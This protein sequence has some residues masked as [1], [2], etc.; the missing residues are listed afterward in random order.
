M[1]LTYGKKDRQSTVMM[2]C[3]RYHSKGKH[4]EENGAPNSI[5][6]IGTGIQKGSDAWVVS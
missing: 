3:D 5:L 6:K 2:L 1:D 4:W